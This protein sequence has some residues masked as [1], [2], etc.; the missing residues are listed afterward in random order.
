MDEPKLLLCQ[1]R[2]LLLSNEVEYAASGTSSQRHSLGP[3]MN[4]LSCGGGRRPVSDRKMRG[5]QVGLGFRQTP[6]LAHRS[7]QRI[8]GMRLVT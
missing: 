3:P 6:Q 8:R 2:Y 4:R 5:A 1:C 7:G